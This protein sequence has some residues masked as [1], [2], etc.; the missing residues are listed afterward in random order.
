MMTMPLQVTALVVVAVT[1][2]A[3]DCLMTSRSPWRGQDFDQQ[4]A[5]SAMPRKLPVWS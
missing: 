5:L 2:L 1:K 4:D 3:L